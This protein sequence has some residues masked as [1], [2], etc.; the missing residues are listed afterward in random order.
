M[1]L[2][3][4]EAHRQAGARG[5]APAPEGAPP[6]NVAALV[7]SSVLGMSSECAALPLMLHG[8]LAKVT[9]SQPGIAWPIGAALV[10][11][12]LGLISQCTCT[13]CLRARG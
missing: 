3:L 6:V 12:V 1:E 2:S 5:A 13:L 10:P 9:S 7:P 11:F 8:I 4:A